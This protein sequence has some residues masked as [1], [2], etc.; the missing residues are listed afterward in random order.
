M[1]PEERALLDR[2]LKLSEENHKILKKIERRFRW[3][4]V[5]GFIKAA[6]IIVPLVAG[7]LF[8]EP[9]LDEVL[10]NYSGV[11]ETLELLR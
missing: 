8:L 6:I 11:K 3:A 10:E 7:Y 4:V 1:N 5:W 2:S 9:Y